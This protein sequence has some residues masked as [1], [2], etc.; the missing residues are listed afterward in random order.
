LLG[1]NSNLERLERNP[2]LILLSQ[3]HFPTSSKRQA[4][5]TL[6]LLSGIILTATLVFSRRH[7]PFRCCCRCL[8][9]GC[10][11]VTDTYKSVDWQAVATVGGMMSLGFALEKTGAAGALARPSSTNFQWLVQNFIL[12]VLLAST[13]VL[14]N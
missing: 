4:I 7:S 14:I 1:H 5:I 8:L 10:V 2:N 13:V 9:L 3:K 12:G 6:L 11:K